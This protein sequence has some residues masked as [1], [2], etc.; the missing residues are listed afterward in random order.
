MTLLI[1]IIGKP[2]SGKSTFLNASCLTHVEMSELPFTT[3]KPN[4]GVATVRSKC[5]CKELNLID[6]PQNSLCINGVRLIPINLLD[7]AGLVP[8]AHKGKGLGN[9]F[10]NDLSKADILIHIIDTTGSLD[11]TGNRTISG[12]HDPYED[13]LFL[14]QEINLWY[15]KIIEREDWNK[16]TRAFSRI[17]KDFIRALGERLS[18]LRITPYHIKRALK[19][20]NLES[21]NPNEWSDDDL[22]IYS[23]ILREI[24]KPIVLVANKIDKDSSIENLKKIKE[25]NKKEIIPC[26]ALTEYILR[27]YEEQKIISYLPGSPSFEILKPEKLNPK[28]LETLDKIKEKILQEFGGTGIQKV[29]KYAIFDILEQICVY[30][31]SDINK[32]TDNNNNVLPDVFLIKKGTKLIDFVRDKIHSDLADHFIHGIDAKT[33]KRLGENYELSH[34][35]II[36]IVSA[37]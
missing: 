1:G 4:K 33:K 28:E 14:E 37:K 36:K 7:V 16:F 30:P 3:I 8:D 23:K 15:K 25:K 10:L 34:N 6:N 24:S 20:S 21:K 31:V 18:G 12:S 22:Y 26:S 19:D 29:F 9:Q 2:S 27:Q 32:F 11:K 35:D 13:I 17:Q 5:V